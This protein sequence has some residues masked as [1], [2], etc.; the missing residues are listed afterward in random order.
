MSN[1]GELGL[2][3]SDSRPPTPGW[4]FLVPSRRNELGQQSLETSACSSQEPGDSQENTPP[5]SPALGPFLHLPAKWVF[6]SVSGR[7]FVAHALALLL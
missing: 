7:D 3:L 5:T 2:H 1:P 4:A 6:I